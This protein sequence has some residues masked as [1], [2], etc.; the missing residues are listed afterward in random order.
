M[1]ADLRPDAVRQAPKN[2]LSETEQAAIIAVCNLPR[3]ASLPPTQIVPTLL[4]EGMYHG[5]ESTFYSNIAN[6]TIVVVRLP[7]KPQAP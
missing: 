3:F 1:S 7:L 6:L 5:S 4:D 2:K